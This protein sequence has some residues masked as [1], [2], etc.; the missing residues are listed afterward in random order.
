MELKDLII[1]LKKGD[2]KESP[3]IEFKS[4]L[5]ANQSIFAKLVVAMT[6][7]G[8]GYIIIGIANFGKS[9]RFASIADPQKLIS[10]MQMIVED[11]TTNASC[12]YSTI[13]ITGANIIIVEVA[14]S[15]LTAIYSRKMTSPERES[16]YVREGSRTITKVS[17]L[18]Y[19]KVYKYMTLETFIS[20]LYN[21]SWRFFEPSKWNDKYESRFYCA[22]YVK[23][24][25]VGK[26]PQLFATCVTRA[27]NSEAAWKVYA[28][29]QGLNAHCV[30]LELDIAALR[31]EIR[32]SQFIYE[33]R[34]V[35]YTNEPHILKLHKPKLSS[36]LDNNG[37]FTVDTFLK[38]LSLKREAYSYEQEVRLFVIPDLKV[39]HRNNSRNAKQK[40]LDFDWSNVIKSVRIDTQCSDAELL[41][42]QQACFSA[43]INPVIPGYTFMGNIN[44]PANS[45]NIPFE[46]F[47]IDDMPSSGRITIK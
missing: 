5:P 43:K 21:R 7:S 13:N 1:A 17:S 4:N 26:T 6:N 22:K 31:Q 45:I 40:D 39:L 38:L 18:I 23:P 27:K 24:S 12:L 29:G 16:V 11:Y 42:I 3:S 15:D 41:V 34:E 30:Q 28:H 2:L 47:N 37:N 44:P 8:G 10:Q 46:R 35:Y 14:K 20:C 19:R 33:E 25:A 36:Y 9:Y 32:K